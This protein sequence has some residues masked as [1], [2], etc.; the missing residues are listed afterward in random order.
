MLLMK[1]NLVELNIIWK[2]AKK[3]TTSGAE[4]TAVS[5]TEQNYN[6]WNLIIL[7]WLPYVIRFFNI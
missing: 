7:Q 3:T 4:S 1:F 2:K 5:F 6:S